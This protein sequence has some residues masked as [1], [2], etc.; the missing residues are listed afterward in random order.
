M[1]KVGYNL[2]LY[3][4]YIFMKIIKLFAIT[5]LSLCFTVGIN[6]LSPTLAQSSAANLVQKG[7]QLLQQGKAEAA[8]EIWQEAEELYRQNQNQ[9]GI[10]GTKINQAQALTSL[11]FYGRSCNLVDHSRDVACKVSTRF[12]L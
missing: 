6:I 8:L 3:E 1:R 4:I 5:L 2:I 10:I 11:G 12:W 7:T 9:T